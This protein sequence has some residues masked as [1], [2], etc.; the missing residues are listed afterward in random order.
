MSNEPSAQ[1][2][3]STGQRW[4]IGFNVCVSTVALLALLIMVNYVAARHFKRF[5]WTAHARFEL[6]PLTIRMLQTITNQVNVVVLF[7]ATDPLFSSVS[8][9]MNEYRFANP[10]IMVET[11]DY[12]RDPSGAQLAKA[13]YKLDSPASKDMVIFACNGRTKVVY[14]KELSDYDLSNVV[15][16]KSQEVKR[17]AFKGEMLFTSAIFDVTQDRKPKAYFLQGHREH[18]PDSDEQL[19]GYSKFTALLASKNIVVNK[20]SLQDAEEVPADCQLLI[21]A[22]PVDPLLPHELEKIEKY[23]NQGGR[24]FLLVNNYPVL[25]RKSG[26]EKILGKWGV[27]IGSNV[28]SDPDNR[29]ASNDLILREFSDHLIVKPLAESMLYMILARS[30]SKRE[31]GSSSAD[32]AQV[33]ELVFTGPNGITMSDIGTNGIAPNPTLDRRGK[34]PV[35]VAVEKGSIQGITADRG[36]TRMVVV[37]ESIFLG[38]ET[39]GKAANQDFANLAVS[40]L[41]DRSQLMGGIEP[42]PIKEYTIMLTQSQ[43]VNVRWILLGGLPGSV[44]LL[45]LV[46]WFRRRS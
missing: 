11:I 43:M 18:N 42:R 16:G 46:V 26:L 6:H 32:A 31:N 37:G 1:V 28:V 36:S 20:L 13:K 12:T 8:G 4:R 10:K 5:Q 33:K 21:I 2:S 9:L 34:I 39:I 45:G 41:L 40:W 22:G 15:S 14:G 7:D 44:L 35:M 19:L 30:V 25:V 27:V 38:N 29:I 23:L 17:K 24:L 3:F